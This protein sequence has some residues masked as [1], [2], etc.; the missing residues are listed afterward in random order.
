MTDKKTTS[1]RGRKPLKPK[2][3]RMPITIFIP[4]KNH[5]KFINEIEPIIQKYLLNS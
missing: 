2:E 4:L 5:T 3:K 1:N